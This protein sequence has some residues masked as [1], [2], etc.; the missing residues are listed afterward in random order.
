MRMHIIFHITLTQKN[1][2]NTVLQSAPEACNC[3]SKCDFTYYTRPNSY[4]FTLGHAVATTIGHTP[5]ST[6]GSYTYH[7]ALGNYWRSSM[8]LIVKLTD[9]RVM[10]SINVVKVW[11]GSASAA[12]MMATSGPALGLAMVSS[13]GYVLLECYTRI[14]CVELAEWYL[15]IVSDF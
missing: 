9:S 3:L 15:L 8:P 7:Y 5:A 6:T 14:P 12:S 13:L 2:I 10:W 11:I 1:G 4:V